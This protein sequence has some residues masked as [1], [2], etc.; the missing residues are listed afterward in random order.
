MCKKMAAA[1]NPYFTDENLFVISCDFSHYPSYNDA[2]KVDQITALSIISNSPD[3][4]LDAIKKN[5]SGN[6]TG[7]VTSC[8]SWPGVLTLLYMTSQ[9]QGMNLKLV[10][11]RNSGDIPNGDRSGVVGYNAIAAFIGK[12]SGYSTKEF[13]LSDADK[14]DLLSLAR[15]TITQFLKTNRNPS[16]EIPDL[17]DAVKTPCGAF[18]TLKKD[19]ELRGCIGNFSS[20]QPLYKVVQ[21]M[22]LAS[23]FQD[24]RFYPVSPGE[25]EKIEVEISVLTPLKPI[26]SIDEFVLGKHGIYMTSGSKSGT[27]LPQVAEETKWT[28]EE[29]LGHCARDKAGIGWDGWKSAQLYTYEAIV[30]SEG[31][32]RKNNKK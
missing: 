19:G 31:Q 18:V 29:F 16:S 12:T 8:C 25:M 32:F 1:L 14:T 2:K 21:D 6:I 20:V 26:K 15:E 27:F 3:S 22:A 23:A 17:S 13:N 9:Q 10:E 28:K 5:E 11:Y 30:F 7:L 24:T 4:F